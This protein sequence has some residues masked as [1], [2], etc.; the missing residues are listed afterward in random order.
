MGKQN[1]RNK[2]D[3]DIYAFPFTLSIKLFVTVTD[4]PY[5]I[6]AQYGYYA[7]DNPIYSMRVEIILGYASTRKNIRNYN[8]KDKQHQQ[9]KTNNMRMKL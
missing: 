2:N 9:N 1:H 8:S 5:H 6:L 3:Q 4:N 7:H